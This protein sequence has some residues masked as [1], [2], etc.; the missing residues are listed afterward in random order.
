[1]N[2]QDKELYLS[3]L[4]QQIAKSERAAIVSGEIT[5]LLAL[6]KEYQRILTE[7]N[8]FNTNIQKDH[9]KETKN[10]RCTHQAN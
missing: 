10:Q 5:P 1:M 3:A 4:K 8:K 6:K 7:N 9:E 2:I